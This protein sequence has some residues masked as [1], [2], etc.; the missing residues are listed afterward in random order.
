[1]V[2]SK[3]LVVPNIPLISLFKVAKRLQTIKGQTITLNLKQHQTL[4]FDLKTTPADYL[5]KATWQYFRSAR[6]RNN[7]ED[8]ESEQINRSKREIYLSAK[9]FNPGEALR[10]KSYEKDSENTT[11]RFQKSVHQFL[12]SDR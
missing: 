8:R 7:C 6:R 3:P 12:W 5:Q 4:S 2:Q 1:M 10:A 9:R 11:L